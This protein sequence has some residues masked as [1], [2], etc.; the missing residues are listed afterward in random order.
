MVREVNRPH[1]RWTMELSRGPDTALNWEVS[2]SFPRCAKTQACS[3]RSWY[4]QDIDG[5]L[6]ESAPRTPT[7]SMV[8]RSSRDPSA[9][10]EWCL[11]CMMQ[12]RP[13]KAVLHMLA[14]RSGLIRSPLAQSCRTGLTLFVA[15]V[16]SLPPHNKEMAP[17]HESFS[18]NL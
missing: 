1:R 6:P 8:S 11:S 9:P 16:L 15:V 18:S 10:H 4:A 12:S 3:R 5:Y 14:N 17:R 7:Q 13:T 2:S